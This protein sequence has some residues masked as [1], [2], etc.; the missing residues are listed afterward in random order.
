MQNKKLSFRL[1][2]TMVAI[3]LFAGFVFGTQTIEQF[4]QFLLIVSFYIYADK[5]SYTKILLGGMLLGAG[6]ETVD[7]YYQL[8]NSYL[9][10]HDYIYTIAWIALV[11]YGWYKLS[12]LKK[13]L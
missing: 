6:W 12:K 1:L 5:D 10:F 8:N 9:H 11:L 2:V 3:A 13:N 7:E 4:C